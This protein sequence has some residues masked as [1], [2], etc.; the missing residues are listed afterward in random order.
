MYK[1]SKVKKMHYIKELVRSGCHSEKAL[2]DFP[3][4]LTHCCNY[5]DILNKIT[6]VEH[7]FIC[8]IKRSPKDFLIN[9]LDD[10]IRYIHRFILYN[11]NVKKF[12]FSNKKTRK[13]EIFV[14]SESVD[15]KILESY[16]D[17]LIA[18]IN[19]H[20]PQRIKE[21]VDEVRL[22]AIKIFLN[23]IS[24]PNHNNNSKLY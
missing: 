23:N 19:M 20:Y 7:D 1:L 6:G 21:L 5:Y 15:F 18:V 11:V 8:F 10:K 9:F 16:Y 12:G 2:N 13:F 4:L 17:P 14:A 22:N 3:N 24:N